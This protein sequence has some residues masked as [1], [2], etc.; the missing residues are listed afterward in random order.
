MRERH[1]DGNDKTRSKGLSPRFE[2]EARYHGINK[3]RGEEYSWDGGSP[4][5]IP[6]HRTQLYSGA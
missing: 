6:E 5:L 1:H 3:D 4:C 2:T